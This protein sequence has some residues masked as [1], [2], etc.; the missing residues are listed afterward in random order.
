[1]KT[2]IFGTGEIAELA[3]YYFTNDSQYDIVAFVADDEYINN[4][5]F[6]G[7]PLVK[8][9]EVYNLYPPQKYKAHVALSYNKLNQIR[10]E[11]YNLMKNL[12]Y[13]LVSYVCSK[14]VTW[15]D[16][17]IGD[18]CFILENQT[19]QP[20]VKIGNNVMIWSTNHLGHN[21]QIDDHAYLASGITISG[22]TKIGKRTF[23]GVNASFKDFITIGNDCFITMGAIVTKDIPKNSTVTSTDIFLSDNV[24]NQKLKKKYFNLDVG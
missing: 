6:K 24:V 21:C 18:N 3:Y 17:N 20:T 16:L 23:V 11:K 14:S 2:L 8:A 1:M 13:D 19:I 22:H 15:P 9:S 5:T 7:L 10:E 12:G 4:S